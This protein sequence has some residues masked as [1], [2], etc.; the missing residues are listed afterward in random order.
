MAL[1]REKLK[2]ARAGKIIRYY[3]ELETFIHPRAYSPIHLLF[4]FLPL[5][6]AVYGCHFSLPL[7]VAVLRPGLFHGIVV[8][9]G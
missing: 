1:S 7:L 6:F 9:S 8:N 3:R 5:L 4:F 2:R